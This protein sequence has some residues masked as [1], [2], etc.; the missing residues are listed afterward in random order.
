MGRASG[1]PENQ[2][3]DEALK[4]IPT[5]GWSPYKISKSRDKENPDLQR[6]NFCTPGSFIELQREELLSFSTQHEDIG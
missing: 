2:E 1:F 6:P 5:F 3:K 4:H